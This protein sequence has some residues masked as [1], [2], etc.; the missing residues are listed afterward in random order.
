MRWRGT[1]WY[2]V[3]VMR[4]ST[5]IVNNNHYPVYV[6]SKSHKKVNFVLI[7]SKLTKLSPSMQSPRNPNAHAS[8]DDS[9]VQVRTTFRPSLA[10]RLHAN[11]LYRLSSTYGQH[12]KPRYPIPPFMI[13]CST[14]LRHPSSQWHNFIY[15]V[16]A[17]FIYIYI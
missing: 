9:D 8:V 5:V 2:N 16:M 13:L 6:E 7:D 3:T 14:L 11:Y 15:S 12:K 1:T 17:V 4:I 10:V